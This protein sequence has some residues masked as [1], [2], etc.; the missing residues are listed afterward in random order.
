MVSNAHSFTKLKTTLYDVGIPCT[1]LYPTQM[2]N[3]AKYGQEPPQWV[4]TEHPKLNASPFS[5]FT[6]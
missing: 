1:K 3:V 6:A 5:Q 2:K 4:K